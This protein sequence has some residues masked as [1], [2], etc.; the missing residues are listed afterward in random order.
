MAEEF[1]YSSIFS[2]L[3][4]APELVNYS[5]IFWISFDFSMAEGGCD[6]AEYTQLSNNSFLLAIFPL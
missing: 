3:G 5:R 6:S 1:H 2:V 4:P